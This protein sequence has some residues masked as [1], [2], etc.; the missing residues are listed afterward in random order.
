VLLNIAFDVPLAM[1]SLAV[2]AIDTGT[3]LAPAIALAYEKAEGDVMHRKPRNVQK[4]RL[5]SWGLLSYSYIQI[6]CIE[7]L[8][9]WL[10]FLLVFTHHNVP[11]KDLAWSA[12]KYWNSTADPY[13]LSNGIVLSRE[14]QLIILGQAQAIYWFLVVACQIIHVYLVRTRT[15]SIL[16][17]GIFGNMV[18]N[19][20]V[21]VEVCVCGLVLFVPTL[22]ADVMQFNNNIPTGLWFLFA[23]GW[24]VMFLY[25]EGFKWMKRNNRGGRIFQ[26]FGY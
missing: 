3:E 5:A 4:D 9:A 19:Y 17:H 12:T 23:L 11:I 15:Q 2:L 8:V 7:F 20:G 1:N 21:V 10:G 22:S 6:G 14:Q 13:K 16:E 25:I 18:L 24:G 26:S